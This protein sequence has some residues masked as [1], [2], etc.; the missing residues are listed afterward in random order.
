M[1]GKI[2]ESVDAIWAHLA[3]RAI[4]VAITRADVSYAQLAGALTREGFEESSRSVEG[5]VQRGTFRFSF[6][7]EALAVSRTEY[8]PRW[9][10]A[11]GGKSPW[12]RRASRIVRGEL[13]LSPWLN[14]KMLSRRLGEIG[15]DVE[16]MV[17]SRQLDEG[18]FAAT[19]FFQCATVCRF[20]GV[21]LFLN[22][23][24]LNK[25]AR[26]GARASSKR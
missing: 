16:P 22:H 1:Q 6:F 14:D 5:K 21:Q 11:F 15:V 17:L 20:E 24:D 2:V 25:A 9:Q 12:E 4:R 26:D 3:S 13:A 18:T 19:L 23:A 10:F 8:P 7:L